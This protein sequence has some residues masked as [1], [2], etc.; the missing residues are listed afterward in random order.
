VCEYLRV[1]VCVC[2]CVCERE[3]ERERWDHARCWWRWWGWA[4][5]RKTMQIMQN[6]AWKKSN[7]H[8]ITLGALSD[9]KRHNGN[10]WTGSS[11]HVWATVGFH[12]LCIFSLP[13]AITAGKT[14]DRI[15]RRTSRRGKKLYCLSMAHNNVSK[16]RYEINYSEVSGL[17]KIN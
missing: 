10:G 15:R 9:D 1:C 12:S 2:V 5:T 3:I 11:E 4:G 8:Q 7:T 6:C 16:K 14:F 13:K 17:R